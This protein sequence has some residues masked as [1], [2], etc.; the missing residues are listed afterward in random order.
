MANNFASREEITAHQLAKI[1]ELFG[2][3]IPANRFYTEKFSG[4]KIEFVSL[5]IFP[6]KS[7]SPQNKN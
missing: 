2:A 3:I 7:P 1:R 5:E 4:I 6:R